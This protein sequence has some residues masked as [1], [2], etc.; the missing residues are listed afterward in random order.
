MTF[1]RSTGILLHPISLPSRGGIGDLGPSAYEFLDF[2]SQARQGLWQVLPLNPPAKG[3]SPYSSTS[4]FAGNPLL[5]SLERLA[6]HGWLDSGSI[7]GLTSDV[8]PIDYECVKHEKL[9]LLRQ[10]AENFVAN[11]AGQ[12]RH[13]FERFCTDNAWWLEDYVMF[14]LLRDRHGENWSQWPPELARHEG[15]A[16]E[17]LQ[18]ESSTELSSRRVIQFFFWEQWHALRHYCAQ[19][20]ICVVGDIAIFVDYDSA[21]VW[22]HRELFRLR[23]DNLQPEV[24]S[25]VPPDYFSANGQRWGNPLYNWDTIRATGYGWWVQRLRWATQ[26]C[27]FIRLDHFRGFAQFWEIP[28]SEPTA[29]QG[30]WVNGPGDELFNRIR[31]ELG[32]LPFFAEDLGLITPDVVALRDRHNIPGMAVL[33][34]AFGDVGAHAYLPHRVSTKSVIYSGTHDNDTTVGWWST[35]G[36]KERAAVRALTGNCDDGPNWGLVRLAQS[37]PAN[38]SI[39]PIQDVL[40]LGSEARLNTPSTAEGNYHW[41]CPVGAFKPALAEKLAALADVTDRLQQ[42]QRLPDDAEFFA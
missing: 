32:G 37:S 8:A 4:A 24:V 34:F 7:S 26:T 12:P 30:R 20:S 36:D 1:P 6:G 28:A 41:R 11:S 2:L 21:D 19:K 38:F 33:Q 29:I 22:A 15:P 27:D 10:A 39:V 9:P 17:K 42:V 3:N 31:E 18:Q 5:I 14:D 35:L 13:R 40:G 23:E 16:L 25:G